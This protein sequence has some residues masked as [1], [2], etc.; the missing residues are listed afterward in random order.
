MKDESNHFNCWISLKL[1]EEETEKKYCK[2]V[3]FFGAEEIRVI[4]I[5]KCIEFH[6]LFG[7]YN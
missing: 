6:V 1:S 4:L 5:W 7:D 3:F 2:F